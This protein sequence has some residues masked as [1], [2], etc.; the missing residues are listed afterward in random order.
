M[1]LANC[2]VKSCKG[3][4]VLCARE[5]WWKSP[6]HH[7]EVAV[8]TGRAFPCVPPRAVVQCNAQ[9]QQNHSSR[10]YD[11]TRAAPSLFI[12]QRRSRFLCNAERKLA[13]RR[14]SCLCNA[15]P[16][17]HG[18]HTLGP[19]HPFLSTC[20]TNTTVWRAMQ[21]SRGTKRDKLK[22]TNGAKFAVFFFF[23]ADLFFRWFCRF[24][25]CL[26]ITSFRNRRFS[27]K[28]ADFRRNRFVPFSLSLLVPP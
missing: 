15:N 23:F 1:I 11:I 6:A 17:C 12:A 3:L 27:Q 22:G 26:G 28:T 2:T 13:H 21:D 16:S 4:D 5:G 25:L 8:R 18:I 14:P 24:S 19:P 10:G 9:S 20:H 7:M